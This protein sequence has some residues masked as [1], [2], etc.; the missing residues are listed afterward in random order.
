MPLKG[1]G[2]IA[3]GGSHR[4]DEDHMGRNE[5]YNR[6][7]HL[8]ASLTSQELLSL[9]VDTILHRLFWEEK[10]LR[11]VPQQGADGIVNRPRFACSCSRERVSNML[12]SLGAPEIESILAEREQIEVGCEYCGQQYHFDAVDAAQIF[13][14]PIASPTLVPPVTT[15]Q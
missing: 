1:E 12:R 3:A 5:D 13:T 9:D 15:V 14:V 6:I 8:A 10:L 7:A 2:N 4:D 11:F